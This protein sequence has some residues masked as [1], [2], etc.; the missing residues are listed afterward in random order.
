MVIITSFEASLQ[1]QISRTFEFYAKHYNLLSKLPK[2][3]MSND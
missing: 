1:S 3:A 2:L